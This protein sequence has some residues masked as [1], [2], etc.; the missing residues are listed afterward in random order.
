MP[1][2]LLYG[3]CMCI[4]CVCVW[5]YVHAWCVCCVCLFLPVITPSLKYYGQI[6]EMIIK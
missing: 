4:A 5:M 2:N 3:V 1:T 6:D